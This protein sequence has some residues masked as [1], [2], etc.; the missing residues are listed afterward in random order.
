MSKTG[1]SFS[2]ALEALKNGKKL[3]RTG[4]NGKGLYIYHVPANS[5]P[6]A[7][8]IA[9]E[10]FGNSVPYAAYLALK[11]NDGKVHTW[12]PSISDCLA[13]DWEIVK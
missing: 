3:A 10:E 4:W 9:K 6:P 7:S 1:F 11:N 13:E 12:A 2:I 5:Y 8:K